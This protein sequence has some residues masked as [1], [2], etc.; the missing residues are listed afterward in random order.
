MSQPLDE[1]TIAPRLVVMDDYKRIGIVRRKEPRPTTKWIAEQQHAEQIAAL[2][3]DVDWWGVLPLTGGYILCPE[4]FLEPLRQA[5][6]EDFLT[7]VEYG[8]QDACRSLADLFPDFVNRATEAA[9]SE[10]E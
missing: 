2:P 9:R 1:G 7:A 10:R 8:N 3:P 5:T 4:P 6:Y